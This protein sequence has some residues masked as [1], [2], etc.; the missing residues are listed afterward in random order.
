MFEKR[1]VVLYCENRKHPQ[2][3]MKYTFL[4]LFTWA[5]SIVLNAQVLLPVKQ[6]GK[7]GFINNAGTLKVPAIY[8]ALNIYNEYGY[9]VVQK[10][11]KLGLI[12][13][14]GKE[15][16]PIIYDEINVL[17]QHFFEVLMQ[18]KWMLINDL[19]NVLLNS[20][21]DLMLLDA[22]LLGYQNN[23]NGALLI[24]KAIL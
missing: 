22:A 4:L 10:K 2:C 19:E 9:A 16:L 5:M 6:N 1:V 23:K 13:S 18:H 15:Q 3:P 11:D 14:S 7:W 24:S 17:N 12:N 20:Y 8:D 21:E